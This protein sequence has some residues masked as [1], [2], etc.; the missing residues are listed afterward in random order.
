MVNVIF[1]NLLRSKY[2]IKHIEVLPGT[3]NNII[4]Q[5]QVIY[6]EVLLE[7]FRFS[8]VFVNSNR[9]VDE[10]KFNE[11]VNDGDEVVFTHFIGGG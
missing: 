1:L 10:F 3:I 2:N 8:V 11:M 5:I 4:E 6:P 7:D 9:V